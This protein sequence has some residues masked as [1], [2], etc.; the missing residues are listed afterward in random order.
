MLYDDIIQLAQNLKNK[1]NEVEFHETLGSPHM[2]FNVYEEWDQKGE[3]VLLH[4]VV[5]KFI[6]GAGPGA[7]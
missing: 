3:N 7:V 1:G 6:E 2:P 4:A 5:T